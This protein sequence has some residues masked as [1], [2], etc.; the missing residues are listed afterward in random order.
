VSDDLIARASTRIAAPA[1]RV[2]RALTDPAEIEKYYFGSKVES[3]WKAGSPITW[4][5]EWQ[6]KPYQDKGEILEVQPRRRMRYTHYSPMTGKPDVP[7]NYHAITIDLM[8]DGD[9]TR[10]SLAQDG[11]ADAQARD[12]SAKNWATMLDGLKKLIES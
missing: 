11:N 12:H 6:G 8:P 1:E 2:W 5:G 7:E 3:D 10:V 4:N 9:G